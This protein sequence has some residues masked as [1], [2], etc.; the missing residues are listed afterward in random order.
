MSNLSFY[1]YAFKMLN[2]L[3]M[4]L[5]R[6]FPCYVDSAVFQTTHAFS[7]KRGLLELIVQGKCRADD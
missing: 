7:G 5:K 6:Q 4:P 2:D 1:T 3:G